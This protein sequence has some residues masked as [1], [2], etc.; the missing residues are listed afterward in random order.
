[1]WLLLL[2][3]RTPL[4]TLIIT[5]SISV[6]GL[7]L[8]PGVTPEG[9]VYHLSF[10]D[11][12]YL[13]SYTATTIGF[14][15]IPYPFT[16]SQ[17][18]WMLFVMYS[19]VIAWLY[20]IGSVLAVLSDPAFRRLRSYQRSVSRIHGIKY[21]YW[22]VCGYGGAGSQLIRFLDQSGIRCVMI[23]SN[24]TRADSA[25]L[26]D[27]SYELDILVGDVAE[28]Q[29]LVDAGVQRALC[30]GVLALTDQDQVNLTVA[31]NTRILAPRVPVYARS[32]T[33][34]NT[35]NLRSFDTEVVVDPFR[36][37]A[38]SVTQLIRKPNAFALYHELVDPDLNQIEVV[39]IPTSGH[40]IV[41]AT[42]RMAETMVEAFVREH[43]PFCLVSSRA[44]ASQGDW[45]WIQGVG[46]EAQ[47]LREARISEAVGLVAA[48]NDDGDNLSILLTA[49]SENSKLITVARRNKP[50]SEPVFGQGH[51]NYVL[52]EGRIIAQEMY[53]RITTPLLHQFLGQ[54]EIM[55]EALVDGII[56]KLNVR[57]SGER[58][59]LAHFDLTLDGDEAPGVIP[60]LQ[61]AMAPK[62]GDLLVDPGLDHPSM[63]L[64]CLLLV[65][66]NGD[67]VP[68][69]GD[70]LQ[71]EEG[72]RLLL[73]GAMG[74]H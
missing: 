10:L 41:C 11:A 52:R 60:F 30:R 16:P 45:S 12:F 55:P 53:A 71:L 36:V 65:R 37:A 8:I 19:T 46:T 62:L 49:Q 54:L 23:D 7:V 21:P 35:R 50:T 73:W 6:L 74:A 56:E 51:F 5:Y 4:I 61:T 17:K 44:P 39:D 64:I 22:I 25:R 67:L 1:M 70:G 3:L 29:T 2:E 47:T 9:V 59:E 58:P 15:E 14:G 72:D 68:F 28:P 32:A 42:G 57:L 20:S 40:W 26:S 13:V 66:L 18:L 31:T 63:P 38:R 48:T 24:V 27:L 33:D 69:P 43:I 34:A